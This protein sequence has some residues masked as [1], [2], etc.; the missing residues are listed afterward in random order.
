MGCDIHTTWEIRRNGKWKNL[1]TWE[2]EEHDG[3]AVYWNQNGPEIIEGRNYSLFGMLANVRNGYGFAGVDTGDSLV[4]I[5]MPKGS[6]SDAAPETARFMD[7]YESDGHSHSYLT[8]QEL[9]AYDFTR[10]VK[11]RGCVSAA[12]FFRW[13]GYW[14]NRGESPGSYCGAVGGGNIKMLTEDEMRGAIETKRQ[15]IGI[16]NP[17]L[18]RF[19]IEHELRKALGSGGLNRDGDEDMSGLYC[20][21]EW[22]Q[23]YYQLAGELTQSVIPRMLAEAHKNGVSYDDVRIVFFFDN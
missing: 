15:R 13:D 4:P 10:T 20:D 11:C 16:D 9:L 5:A 21:A 14:R 6:P 18:D 17:A 19:K 22:Q 8:L 2:A 23:L 12:E 7:S 3:E 1:D